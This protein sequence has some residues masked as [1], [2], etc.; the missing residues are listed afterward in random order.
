MDPKVIREIDVAK[1]C[2]WVT[3][4]MG[5]IS[6]GPVAAALCRRWASARS[7][8]NCFISVSSCF[9]VPSLTQFCSLRR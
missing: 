3:W 9:T 6:T 7:I 2:D 1:A 8:S 4:G 5:N